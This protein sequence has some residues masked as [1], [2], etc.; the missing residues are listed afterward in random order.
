[1]NTIVYTAITGG[2]DD[3]KRQPE[4]GDE[5]IAFVDDG[6]HKK[7]TPWKIRDPERC[8]SNAVLTAKWHKMMPHVIFPD[9]DYS[10]WIDGSV[11]MEGNTTVAQLVEKYMQDAD[12]VLFDHYKRNCL[13]DEACECINKGLGDKEAIYRQVSTYTQEGY[14]PN[15]GLVEA[16]VILRKRNKTV[17]AFDEAWWEEVCR[18]SVCDQI[19]FNFVAQ[20]MGMRI[21]YFPGTI[22]DNI[23]FKKHLHKRERTMLFILNRLMSAFGSVGTRMHWIASLIKVRML[24]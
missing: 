3:L 9:C 19:S 2:Y 23:L 22:H 7:I 4:T 11:T 13:Y 18:H 24:Q 20:K 15:N 21:D 1:M 17:N 6:I 8:C 12:M 14:P 16:T 10:L 5:F